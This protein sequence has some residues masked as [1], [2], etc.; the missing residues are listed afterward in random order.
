MN[1]ERPR[2]KD[3]YHQLFNTS[4]FQMDV[5]GERDVFVYTL[6]DLLK[7]IKLKNLGKKQRRAKISGKC[8]QKGE[9]AILIFL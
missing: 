6:F 7:I 5:A 2:L 3:K 9:V 8:K 1:S 4:F